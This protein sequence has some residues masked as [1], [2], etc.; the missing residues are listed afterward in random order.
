[1]DGLS[2][3]E[4]EILHCIERYQN[5][6]GRTPSYEEIRES[7]GMRSKDHVFRDVKTL[8]QKGYV[9]C[10]R[11]V[12][13]GIRLLR[14]ANG[15]P[16]STTSISIPALGY[17]AAGEPIPLPEVNQAPLDWVQI[18]REMLPDSEDVFAVRIRGNSMMDALVNDGD[19]V[20]MK[21]QDTARNGELVAVRLKNDPTNQGITLKRFFRQNGHVVLQPENPQLQAQQYP[22]GDVEIQGKVLCVI[23]HVPHTDEAP[24]RDNHGQ[25]P[26][27]PS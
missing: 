26:I 23:R 14:T 11:G 17:I 25:R 21:K 19:T 22:A 9:H 18:A 24:H 12:S 27:R 6:F 16:V 3:D 15:Y 8:E 13:R 20:L 2:R 5:Q 10:E 1:M 4:R 7:T